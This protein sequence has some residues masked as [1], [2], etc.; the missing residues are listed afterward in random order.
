MHIANHYVRINGKM[1]IKGERI[2]D[3]LPDEKIKWLMEAGAIHKGASACF[4]PEEP[5]EDPEEPVG[6]PENDQTN[7]IQN[8][9]NEAAEE[10]AEDPEDN[11]TEDTAAEPPE[12]PVGDPE[13]EETEADD[14]A[15]APE[16]DVMAG[17]VQEP[18]EKAAEKSPEEP[19]KTARKPKATA[20]KKTN[21]GKN[22]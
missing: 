17:I 8:P 19:K 11:Q 7:A 9:E 18:T 3:G 1:Y 14:E 5:A 16:I 20:K 15:E 21:G 12:E 22:E 4:M 13:V 2:P 10:P 6:D